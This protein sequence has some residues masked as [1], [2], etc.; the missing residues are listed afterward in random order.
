MRGVLYF[1]H[2]IAGIEIRNKYNSEQ[3]FIEMNLSN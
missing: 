3:D 2:Y 1:V